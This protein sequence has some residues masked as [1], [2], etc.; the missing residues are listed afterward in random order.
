MSIARTYAQRMAKSAREARYRAPGYIP[1]AIRLDAEKRAEVLAS[2]A[3][4]RANAPKVLAQKHNVD[5][6]VIYN[7]WNGGK[8]RRVRG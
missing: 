5:L 2:K 6:S 8:R 7:I 3:I 1:V 4:Y